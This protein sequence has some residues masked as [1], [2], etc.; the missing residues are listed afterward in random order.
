MAHYLVI[1]K[2]SSNSKKGVANQ[3]EEDT[4]KVCQP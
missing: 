2:K 4:L 3:T 1:P